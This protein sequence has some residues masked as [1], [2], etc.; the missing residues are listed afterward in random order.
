M[1]L[2]L[3]KI[4]CSIGLT[5]IVMLGVTLA[6]AGISPAFGQA[7]LS[8]GSIQGAVLD[9]NGSSVPS[10]KVTITSKATGQTMTPEVTSTGEYNS[11]PLT[12]GVY[13][14]RV[15]AGG[16]KAIEK[17][18]TVQVGGVSSGTVT[19]EVGSG[20]KVVTVEASAVQLNT[21]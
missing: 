18:I 6:L 17:T 16:F 20:S 19:L 15:E 5:L 4:S 3:R 11:G 12:P 7:G 21:E 1:M 8:T 13:V 9:P 2:S 14:V 10:A